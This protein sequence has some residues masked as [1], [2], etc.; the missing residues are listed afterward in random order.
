MKC[1]NKKGKEMDLIAQI[2]KKEKNFK[3]TIVLPETKM[4]E[5]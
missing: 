4:K 5:F 1:F 3:K 2:K